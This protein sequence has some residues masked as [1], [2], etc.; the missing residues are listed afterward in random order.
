M[1]F[2]MVTYE[3]L[4]GEIRYGVLNLYTG[5]LVAGLWGCSHEDCLCEARLWGLL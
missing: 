4:R 1:K 3:N 5:K 2:Q